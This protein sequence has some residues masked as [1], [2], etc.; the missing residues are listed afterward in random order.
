MG[1]VSKILNIFVLLMALLAGNCYKDNVYQ[2]VESKIEPCNASIQDLKNGKYICDSKTGLPGVISSVKMSKT[3]K[4]GHAKFTYQLT[5]PF[6]NQTSQ[7]MHPGHTHLHRPIMEKMELEVSDVEESGRVETMLEDGSL[8]DLNMAKDYTENK[9]TDPIGQKFHEA[10]KQVQNSDGEK[11]LFVSILHGPV[12][13]LKK[14][15]MVRQICGWQI[16]NYDDIQ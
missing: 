7:E 10:W 12:H 16:K 1:I 15:Y 3:G 4:H 9:G 14:I 8:W 2:G 6:T 5:I 11:V 13:D